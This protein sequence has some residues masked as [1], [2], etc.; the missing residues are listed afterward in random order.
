MP[1]GFA[2][3][4]FHARPNDG[5]GR[6][7]WNSSHFPSS[8]L[9][10]S[11]CESRTPASISIKRLR[12]ESNVSPGSL[13]LERCLPRFQ[14]Q[15]EFASSI[16]SSAFS[17]FTSHRLG[18]ILHQKRFSKEPK[19]RF[20]HHGIVSERSLSSILSME[21]MCLFPVFHRECVTAA[22]TEY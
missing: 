8:L 22:S 3:F 18:H 15:P 4:T 12:S 11:S 20:I 16:S 6:F 21:I 2:I 19:T 5:H 14:S 7:E 10:C 13:S 1:N 9:L 17:L